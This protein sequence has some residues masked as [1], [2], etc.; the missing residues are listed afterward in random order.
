M[1]QRSLDTWD[2]IMED[3]EKE[4]K[5]EKELYESIEKLRN[6][7]ARDSL[8]TAERIM[9]FEKLAEVYAKQGQFKAVQ[10]FRKEA[11]DIK[12]VQRQVETAQK[13]RENKERAQK[14]MET[15]RMDKLKEISTALKIS[16]EEFE[17]LIKE[18]EA[19]D[20]TKA[21]L[22][23]QEQEW[24]SGWNKKKAPGP[25][26]RSITNPIR[27]LFDCIQRCFSWFRVSQ[28]STSQVGNKQ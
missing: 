7:Q 25:P 21:E 24:G 23:K 1:A 19:E 10:A 22:A 2:K 3:E 16:P 11:E 8:S 15:A 4:E 28:H 13:L 26:A 18:R 17:R 20:K 27:W 5:E 6:E 14:E 9:Q 12:R